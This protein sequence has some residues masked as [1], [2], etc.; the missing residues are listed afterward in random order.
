MSRISNLL[1][2][3]IAALAS[4]AGATNRTWLVP[5]NFAR[6]QY[7]IDDQGVVDGD[8][9]S[10]WGPSPWSQTP[11]YYYCENVNYQGKKLVVANRCFLPGIS[12]TLHSIS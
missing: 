4:V 8:T 5:G 6:I 11:P 9:I 10:V 2:I 7:A 12:G 1:L 3:A